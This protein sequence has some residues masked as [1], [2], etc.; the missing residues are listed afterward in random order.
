MKESDTLSE[1][2]KKN[3]CDKQT[4]NAL[5]SIDDAF[6]KEQIG[7]VYENFNCIGFAKDI[8]YSLGK[9]LLFLE[10]FLQQPEEVQGRVKNWLKDSKRLFLFN[11]SPQ[12]DLYGELLV[13]EASGNLSEFRKEKNPHTQPQ[14]R[15]AYD[16]TLVID[17]NPSKPPTFEE[18][19]EPV[20]TKMAYV[21]QTAKKDFF[22]AFS[23][24]TSPERAENDFKQLSACLINYVEH[25]PDAFLTQYPEYTLQNYETLRKWDLNELC[26]HARISSE[27]KSELISLRETVLEIAKIH[28]LRQD[29]SSKMKKNRLLTYSME[30]SAKSPLDVRFGNDGGCCIGIYE[31]QGHL[32]NAYGLP[33]LIADNGVYIFDINQQIDQNKKRRAGFVLA[34]ETYDEKGGRFLACN[35][36]ELSLAMNPILHC[37]KIVDFAETGLEAFCKANDF[38]GCVMSMH[39]YNTSYKFS[40]SSKKVSSGTG[41]L[42]MKDTRPSGNFYSDIFLEGKI[43]SYNQFYSIFEAPEKSIT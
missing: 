2:E 13:A 25:V 40:S 31:D 5:L 36:L 10:E 21:L 3:I 26:K 39:S 22:T 32:G 14:P 18:S 1:L 38:K 41:N 30:L 6:I 23:E 15:F 29:L 43:P 35:S 9:K 7:K 19:S 20:R 42:K 33:Q 17:H 28:A 37:N 16:K 12:A 24:K 27:L 11:E 8:A 34:F 4:K